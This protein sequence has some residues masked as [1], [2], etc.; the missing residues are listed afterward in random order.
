MGRSATTGGVVA[1]D[2]Q[3]GTAGINAAGIDTAGID[4][5]GIDTTDIGGAR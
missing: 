2:R 5:A 3:T 4:T 1:V